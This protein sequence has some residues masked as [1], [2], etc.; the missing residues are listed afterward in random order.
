MKDRI[1]DFLAFLPREL[2]VFLIS[3]LPIIELRGAIPVGAAIGLPF[4]VNYPVAVLGNLLPVPFILLFITRVIGRMRE[5]KRRFWNK[6]GELLVKRAER[7]RGRIE[8]YAFFGLCLFVAVP[9]PVTGAWTGA[10]VA[11]TV[12][13]HP[14]RALLSILLG[15]L[16]S[17]VIV[18][19][20]AY[21]AFAV[22][23]I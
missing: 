22:F 11:A 3:V 10:L 20:L 7:N 12:G 19:L 6:V 15:V 18:T 8:K 13:M 1:I 21:G 17:G 4:Y 5:S 2:Y 14:V 16:L 9:L 23:S